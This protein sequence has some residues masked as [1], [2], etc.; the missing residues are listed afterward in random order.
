MNQPIAGVT[1][2]ETYQ[3][4]RSIVCPSPACLMV[5]GSG[6]ATVLRSASE[7]QR[8]LLTVTV[9]CPARVSHG[10]ISSDSDLSR[11]G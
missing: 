2:P 1:Q 11:C 8:V 3:V 4:S 5:A 7:S 9:S 6:L 10:E